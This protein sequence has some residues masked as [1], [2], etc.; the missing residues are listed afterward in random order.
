MMR[1]RRGRSVA[2][3]PV[4][5]S[6]RK[7]S[8]RSGSADWLW[9]TKFVLCRIV[10]GLRRAASPAVAGYGAQIYEGGVLNAAKTG[11]LCCRRRAGRRGRQRIAYSSRPMIYHGGNRQ[12]ET[13]LLSRL[14][15]RQ[16]RTTRT[17]DADSWWAALLY[18]P[19]ITRRIVEFS[20][21]L[22]PGI[23]K[24]IAPYRL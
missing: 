21:G 4:R 23:T 14:T 6:A 12:K 16:Q 11:S 13:A 15:A 2:K 10:C 19:W 20:E 7:E 18:R 8:H 3:S 1:T 22:D 5:S 24:A 9:R 17:R